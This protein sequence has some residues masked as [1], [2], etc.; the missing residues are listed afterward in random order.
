[1]MTWDD[2][3]DGVTEEKMPELLE[4]IN[5]VFSQVETYIEKTV[6]EDMFFQEE[7]SDEEIW[8]DSSLYPLLTEVKDKK[9]L[10][11]EEATDLL[12]EVK[13]RLQHAVKY[14]NQ[15]ISQWQNCSEES[16]VELEDILP[17]KDWDLL[18]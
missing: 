18:F 2:L 11:E 9:E 6:K 5:W 3:Y 10:S 12:L 7:D 8:G 14:L 15:K 17:Q 13:D 4:L 16:F 1:M